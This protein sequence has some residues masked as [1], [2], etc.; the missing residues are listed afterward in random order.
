[1]LNFHCK[2]KNGRFGG[3]QGKTTKRDEFEEESERWREN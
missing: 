2:Q 1:M 3:G